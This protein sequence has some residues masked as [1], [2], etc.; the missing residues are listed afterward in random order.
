M[1]FVLIAGDTVSVDVLRSP[2]QYGNVTVNWEIQGLGG[3]DPSQTFMVYRGS[4]EFQAVIHSLY[5]L[6]VFKVQ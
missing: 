3:L 5:S 1:F 4:I 6:D 2:F